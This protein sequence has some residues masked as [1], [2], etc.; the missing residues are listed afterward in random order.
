[1]IQR[2]S[3]E[4]QTRLTT[5]SLLLGH[6]PAICNVMDLY[7]RV[8]TV[9]ENH[10]M[11]SPAL[12]EA[13]GSVRLL[14]TKNHPVPTTAFRA[15]APVNPLG[16]PQLAWSRL[17]SNIKVPLKFFFRSSPF[18]A[19]FLREEN[20]PMTSSALGEVLLLTKNHPVPTHACSAGAPVNPPGSLL[21]RSIRSYVLERAP[22]FTER[23]TD[24]QFNLTFQKCLIK[25]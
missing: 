5:R 24:G 21:L 13:R 18:E 2:C 4:Y 17:Y 25:D 3:S 23:R 1:M 10:P 9:G 19:F 11:T 12:G 15:R 20:H 8:H 22:S 6:V 14:L 16:S 7:R